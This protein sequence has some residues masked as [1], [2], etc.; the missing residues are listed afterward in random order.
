M[1]QRVDQP[2]GLKEYHE[3]QKEALITYVPCTTETIINSRVCVHM[4]APS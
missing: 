1:V 2:K 4:Q 3:M